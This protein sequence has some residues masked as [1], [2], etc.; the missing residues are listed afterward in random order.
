MQNLHTGHRKRLRTK[1]IEGG[2]D[3]LEPHEILELLLFNV[4]PRGNLNETGHLLLNNFD[5]KLYRVFESD[6]EELI[7]VDGIGEKTADFIKLI[8]DVTAEYDK[9]RNQPNERSFEKNGGMKFLKSFFADNP[10]QPRLYALMLGRE[11]SIISID[12][13]AKDNYSYDDIDMRDFVCRVMN[14]DVLRVI[15]VHNHVDGNAIPSNSDIRFTR[16]AE[17]VLGYI[18]IELNDHIVVA[19]K[20]AV[21]IKNDMSG[22]IAK[23][24]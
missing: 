5:K 21:S 2:I 6:R 19:G 22:I 15:F 13:L 12:L 20:T 10:Y 23:Y 8:S 4:V 18:D 7:K 16:F 14:L 1:Y 17:K 24:N 9:R 11:N 3:S